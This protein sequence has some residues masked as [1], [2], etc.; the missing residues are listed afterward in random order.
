MESLEFQGKE[1]EEAL[2]NLE[3]KYEDLFFALEGSRSD[4]PMGLIVNIEEL[5]KQAE[6]S[7]LNEAQEIYESFK[8]E[9]SKMDISDYYN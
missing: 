5:K 3:S 4:F 7:Y 2:E 9:I 6:I 1:L 8:N